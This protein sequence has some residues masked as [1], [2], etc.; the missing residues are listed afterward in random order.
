MHWLRRPFHGGEFPLHGVTLSDESFRIVVQ[1]EAAN[2]ACI[3]HARCPGWGKHART[4]I[5][6]S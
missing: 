6:Y 1:E 2:M 3:R 5:G 4:V